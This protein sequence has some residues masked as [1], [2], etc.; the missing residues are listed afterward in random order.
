MAIDPN[1]Q[2]A[3]VSVFAT[4]ITTLGVIAVAMINN[5][6][7]RV[8][9]ASAGVE[10]GAKIDEMDILEQMLSLVAENQRKEDTISQLRK[11]N[12]QLTEHNSELRA[13]LRNHGRR[14]T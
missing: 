14:N 1:V 8:K 6:K 5:R 3:L 9:S 4:S 10:A 13:Q 11:K 7:E 2:V 12:R